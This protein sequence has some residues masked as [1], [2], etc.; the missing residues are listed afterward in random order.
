MDLP[1]C[2]SLLGPP[3]ACRVAAAL[4]ML[5]TSPPPP[6]HYK[7]MSLPVILIICREITM[8][9]L[10]EWAATSGGAAQTVR[11]GCEEHVCWGGGAEGSPCRR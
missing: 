6:L 5:T 10:R 1:L 9:S 8:S 7:H 3:A 11:A 2:L 4:V